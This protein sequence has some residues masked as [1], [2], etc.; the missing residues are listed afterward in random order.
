M[1]IIR[2]PNDE[3]QWI[4]DESGAI[5]SMGQMQAPK[6]ST[7][8]GPDRSQLSIPDTNAPS[9][10]D[11]AHTNLPGQGAPTP[12]GRQVSTTNYGPVS[13]AYRTLLGGDAAGS[14]VDFWLNQ[15]KQNPGFDWYNAIASSPEAQAYKATGQA[16]RGMLPG[17]SPV[18]PGQQAAGPAGP[19]KASGPGGNNTYGNDP[20]ATLLLNTILQRLQQL[21]KPV[22]TTAQD[23]YSKMALERVGQL[24]GAPFSDQQTSALLTKHM[25]PLTQA[26]DTAKQQAAEDMARRGIGPTSGLFHERMA[27]IDESYQRGAA[28]VT[29]TLNVQGIDQATKNQQMQLALLSSIVDMNRAT[30]NQQEGLNSQ[31]VPTASVGTNLDTTRLAGL[32]NAGNSSD[33]ASLLGSLV[34]LGHLG[35]SSQD[36]A[37]QASAANGY[38]MAQIIWAITHGASELMR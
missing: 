36:Q 25:G 4:D 9:P 18:A 1:A 19:A 28:N 33:P 31:L 11:V 16:Q 3:N 17:S 35:M 7:P 27:K 32:T 22:D 14:E 6:L 34:S 37:N 38:S 24:G 13:D 29:N 12:Q 20:N 21:Q 23:A 2:N 10:Y 30:A 8:G 15:T 5:Q 26:R